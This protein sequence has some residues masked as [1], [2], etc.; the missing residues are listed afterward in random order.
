MTD[1]D[2]YDYFLVRGYAVVEV[3]GLGTRGS[4]GLETC[5]ADV[6]TDAFK[7][8]VEWL[9]KNSSRVAYT[10]KE[11]NIQ[12]KADWSNGNV[13]MT[14]RSYGGTTDFAVAS[15]GVANLK[16]IV[17]VAG[18]ASWYEYTELAGYLDL[19]VIRHI[20]ITSVSTAL[21]VILMKT[22]GTA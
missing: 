21:A 4:E 9:A 10:D 8:V 16:T 2:W 20:R 11:N 3:G 12:I 7:C 6:E 1:L 14:G 22:T 5:G 18:I 15:T 17:P 19:A 13:A